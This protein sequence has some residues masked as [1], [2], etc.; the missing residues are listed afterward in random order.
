[1]E[2]DKKTFNK[3][4]KEFPVR[5]NEG[6]R[7]PTVRIVTDDIG[8]VS[9]ARAQELA[10][11]KGLDLVEIS[12]TRM[13]DGSPVSVCKLCDYNKFIFEKKQKEKMAK[14]QARENEV[15][16]KNMQ[17]HITSDVGDVDRKVNQ[18]IGFLKDGKKVRLE[19]F[20]RGR[21]INQKSMAN[22]LMRGVLS[23]FNEVGIVESQ[24]KWEGRSFATMIRPS[25]GK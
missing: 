14:K 1:M 25:K 5:K 13:E 20:L 23:K 7:S 2:K 16:V 19:I 12:F 8:I 22:D 4:K 9:N 17:L 3:Q 6:V 18:C 21:E 10:R 15:E 24:P 11:S